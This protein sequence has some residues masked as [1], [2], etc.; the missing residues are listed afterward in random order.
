MVDAHELIAIVGTLEE[1][2]AIT[3]WFKTTVPDWCARHDKAN[4]HLRDIRGPPQHVIH[5]QFAEHTAAW[6]AFP[7]GRVDDGGTAVEDGADPPSRHEVGFGNKV[8]DVE[9]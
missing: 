7:P 9:R 8:C 6:N 1:E 3:S 2:H 5:E 4:L